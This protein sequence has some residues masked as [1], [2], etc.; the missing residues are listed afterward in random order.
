M[1]VVPMVTLMCA[2]AVMATMRV[3]STPRAA[4]IPFCSTDACSLPGLGGF[5]AHVMLCK[6]G[7][8]NDV[9]SAEYVHDPVPL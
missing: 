4:S 9:R 7:K 2:V 5:N 8:T 3:V 1:S 6:L